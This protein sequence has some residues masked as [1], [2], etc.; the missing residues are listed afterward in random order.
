MK[1][2]LG[3]PPRRFTVLFPC[4][5]PVSPGTSPRPSPPGSQPARGTA[6][7]S[8]ARLPPAF[9]FACRWAGMPVRPD[10]AL[11]AWLGCLWLGS[12]WGRQA[13]ARGLGLGAFVCDALRAG[14]YPTSALAPQSR[15]FVK[16]LTF[17][18][19]KRG[20]VGAGDKNYLRFATLI[21]AVARSGPRTFRVGDRGGARLGRDS[22]RRGAQRDLDPDSGAAK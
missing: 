16:R 14:W 20:S 8:R 9:L 19:R 18:C 17:A 11:Q 22:P 13:K 5:T 15:E 1:G 4:Q 2:K 12:F 10:P 7:A 21:F 6:V 3:C